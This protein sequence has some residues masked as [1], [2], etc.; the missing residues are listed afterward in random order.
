MT[1]CNI[2]INDSLAEVEGDKY[3]QHTDRDHEDCN[4]KGAIRSIDAL[5]IIEHYL[6]RQSC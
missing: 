1:P 5:T 2:S 3:I 6:G 4:V